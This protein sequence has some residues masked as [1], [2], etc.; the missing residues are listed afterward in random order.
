MPQKE[1]IKQYRKDY[2]DLKSCLKTFK[3]PDIVED[4]KSRMCEIKTVIKI[5]NIEEE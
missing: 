1:K 3:H 2:N 4:I 5:L